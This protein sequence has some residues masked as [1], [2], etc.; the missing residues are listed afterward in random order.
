M[1][2]RKYK[3]K[4]DNNFKKVFKQGRYCQEN[5]IRVKFLKNN[6]EFSRFAFVVG[7]KI[8]KKAV[9]RN[10]IR[11]QLEKATQLV[12]NQIKINFDLVIMVEPEIIK[13]DYQAIEKELI[14]LFKKIKL[15]N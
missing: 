15:I 9:Q 8:S 11:R 10:K 4:R 1:L 13:N 6:L 12:F 14:N 5:F 7:L 2:P 3:L